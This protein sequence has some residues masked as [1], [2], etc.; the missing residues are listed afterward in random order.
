MTI[1]AFTGL[2][3][4]GK[5]TAAQVFIERG[6]EHLKFADGLKGMLTALLRYRGATEDEVLRMLDGDMKEKPTPFLDYRTPR[7]AMQ[8]LG[9]E[10]GR[11]LMDVDFW[12]KATIQRAHSFPNVVISDVRFEN[13]VAAVAR[14]GGRIYRIVRKSGHSSA[15]DLHS[16]EAHIPYLP[17]DREIVNDFPTAEA[18]VAHVRDVL[19]D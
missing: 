13:E 1:I 11:A 9:T 15:V 17:V 4:S 6:Y 8:T 3:G 19:S 2:K 7:H 5:D 16:S 12:A 10:W 14:A 18:F